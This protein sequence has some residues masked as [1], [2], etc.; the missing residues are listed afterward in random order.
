MKRRPSDVTSEGDSR[1]FASIAE[2][3]GRMMARSLLT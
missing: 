2:T 1:R 3:A